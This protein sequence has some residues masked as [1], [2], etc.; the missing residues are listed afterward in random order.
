MGISRT[1]CLGW[2]QTSIFLI[3][4]SQVAEI[5]GVSHK[6]LAR[7]V[8]NDDPKLAINEKLLRSIEGQ[9][10]KSVTWICTPHSASS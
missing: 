10:Q 9:W 6:W 5:T 3:S 7:I 4:A 1:T 2:S 8:L